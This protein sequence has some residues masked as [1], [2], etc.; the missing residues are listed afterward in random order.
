M[1]AR[2]GTVCFATRIGEGRE[3][4]ERRVQEPTEPDTLALAAFADPIHA[5]VPVA[6]T[7]QRQAMD[8]DREALVEPARAMLEQ[9][10]HL[11]G[12][13]GL[14]EAV[15]LAGRKPRPSRKERSHRGRRGRR[16]SR[17]SGR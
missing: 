3:G 7:D 14:E 6:G 8:A 4:G 13:G 1:L 12:N 9:G 16:S 10:G 17:H 11:V 5:V 15:M 2:R